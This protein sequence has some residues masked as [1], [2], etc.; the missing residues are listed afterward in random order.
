MSKNTPFLKLANKQMHNSFKYC[1]KTETRLIAGAGELGTKDY[2]ECKSFKFQVNETEVSDKMI[3]FLEAMN[4]IRYY[5]AKE[6]RDKIEEDEQS[7]KS[8]DESISGFFDRNNIDEKGSNQ[9]SKLII[10]RVKEYLNKDGNS[11]LYDTGKVPYWVSYDLEGKIR[12]FIELQKKAGGEK[13]NILMSLKGSV[14]GN[15]NTSWEAFDKKE[16][17]ETL[18]D[19]IIENITEEKVKRSWT[20]KKFYLWCLTRAL[21]DLKEEFKNI[22]IDEGNG[23]ILKMTGSQGVKEHNILISYMR[24]FI[25][26]YKGQ[27][28]NKAIEDFKLEYSLDKKIN[29]QRGIYKWI[30]TQEEKKQEELKEKFKDLRGKILLNLEPIKKYPS[31][32]SFY[33]AKDYKDR[34]RESFDIEKYVEEFNQLKLKILKHPYCRENTLKRE[35]QIDASKDFSLNE[36]LKSIYEDLCERQKENTKKKYLNNEQ[37]ED[38]IK[39]N[40]ENKKFKKMEDIFSMGSL[41]LSNRK[42]FLRKVY[43]FES[44]LEKAVNSE[45]DF[46]DL[47]VNSLLGKKTIRAKKIKLLAQYMGRYLRLLLNSRQTTDRGEGNSLS[48]NKRLIYGE[49][50]KV[51][52]GNLQME[53]LKIKESHRFSFQF[54]NFDQAKLYPLFLNENEKKRLFFYFEAFRSKSEKGSEKIEIK[55]L[56]FTKNKGYI[57]KKKKINPNCSLKIPLVFPKR[58]GRKFVFNY[59]TGVREGQKKVKFGCPNFMVVYK[60]GELPKLE[61]SIANTRQEFKPVILKYPKSLKKEGSK[62][63]FLLD[64]TRYFIGLDRGE[65]KLFC[66]TVWDNVNKE[67]VEQGEIG[68]KFKDKVDKLKKKEADAQ[69]SFNV[70]E[71]KKVRRKIGNVVKASVDHAINELIKLSYLYRDDQKSTALVF[72]FLSSGLARGGKKAYVELRQLNQLIVKVKEDRNYYNMPFQIYE[73][74]AAFT[75]Q[76]CSKCGNIDPKSRKKEDYQCTSC[77]FKKDADMQASFNIYINGFARWS[78]P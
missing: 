1:Q 54:K 7:G 11:C 34:F 77:D 28:T 55:Y 2:G 40:K 30:K 70:K 22:E 39:E 63:K 32:P 51:L 58:I 48:R 73:I 64:S 72:E 60:K 33:L 62:A 42:R 8:L 67:V 15:Q 49:E 76:A 78:V 35:F 17:K 6:I 46:L 13:K 25:G 65:N 12:S 10:L 66:Y 18:D 4:D 43:Y 38:E 52:T 24:I 74:G 47:K 75:S 53:G 29:S 16:L 9:W 3:Q 41:S 26:Q 57:A 44:D 19:S 31:F 37:S 69:R 59:L 36:E 45:L 14:K 23:K 61:G 71:Y 20:L 5:V 27:R 50:I 21:N 56:A 68:G